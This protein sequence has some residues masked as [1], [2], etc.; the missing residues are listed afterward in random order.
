MCV[1]VEPTAENG[2]RA[3]SRLMVDKVITVPKS[4]LGQCIG[5]LAD[6]DLLRL[7]RSLAGVSGP[8]PLRC[9]PGLS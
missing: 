6:A 7:N 1:P 3:T 8:S 5:H 4:H 9:T 2:L